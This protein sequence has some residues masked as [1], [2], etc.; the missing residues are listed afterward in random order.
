MSEELQEMH[1]R[2]H[3]AHHDPSLAPVTITM[4][5]LAV[6]VASVSLLGH[7]AHTEELLLQNKSTDQWAYYQAKNI[8]S[9]SYEMFIDLLSVSSPKDP[10]AAEKL[11]EKYAGEV[12]RYKEEL[13]EIDAEA[14]KLEAEVAVQGQK[15]ARFGLGEVLLEVSLVVTSITLLTRRRAYWLFGLVLAA[16]GLGVTSLGMLIH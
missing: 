7:R 9:H 3:E 13:K 4:A 15:A 5:I 8:R 14:R 11:K 6:V 16:T 10:E 12:E 1:E 2:A